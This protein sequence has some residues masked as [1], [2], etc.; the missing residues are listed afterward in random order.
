MGVDCDKWYW[1]P[2]LPREGIE[3]IRSESPLTRSPNI[4]STRM[5][6]L[7]FYARMPRTHQG[8]EQPFVLADG[9]EGSEPLFRPSSILLRVEVETDP[10]FICITRSES[11]VGT[12]PY[13]IYCCYPSSIERARERGPPARRRRKRRRRG[14]SSFPLPRA[15]V[16]SVIQSPVA[17]S[18]ERR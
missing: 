9:R 6:A 12:R 7:P 2:R 1:M 5:L 14:D 15:H 8:S 4:T 11:Q 13:S 10:R 17:T 18:G 3:S 16:V